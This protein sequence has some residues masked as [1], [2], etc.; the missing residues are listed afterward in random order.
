MPCLL[1]RAS[2]QP[3]SPDLTVHLYFSHTSLLGECFCLSH[4]HSLTH[5]H[6]L[7]I[8]ILI[9]LIWMLLLRPMTILPSMFLLSPKF[10]SSTL[11]HHHHSLTNTLFHTYI[12]VH[13]VLLYIWI[14]WCFSSIFSFIWCSSSI[15]FSCSHDT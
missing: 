3:I 1:F 6:I 7:L 12:K 14:V 2:G 4:S 13:M 5:T 8:C 10:L 9:D 15:L 11:Y